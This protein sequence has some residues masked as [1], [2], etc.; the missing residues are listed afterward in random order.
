MEPNRSR[1][2]R[3]QIERSTR[4]E[5]S[6]LVMHRREKMCRTVSLAGDRDIAKIE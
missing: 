1:L 2:L 5:C 4:A 3:S 6:A